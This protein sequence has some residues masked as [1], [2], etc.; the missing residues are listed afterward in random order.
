MGG[1]HEHI[2]VQWISPSNLQCSFLRHDGRR[3]TQAAT[4]NILRDVT[5]VG[6]ASTLNDAGVDDSTISTMKD[7]ILA[8]CKPFKGLEIEYHQN[9]YIRDQFGLIV[10]ILCQVTDRK[11]N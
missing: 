3:L 1:E 4:D 11:D 6:F 8:Q 9:A 10:S 7:S 5:K 2:L